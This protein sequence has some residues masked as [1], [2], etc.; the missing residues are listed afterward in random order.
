[1]TVVYGIDGSR[2][3]SL[4]DFWLAMGEA[5]NGPGGYFGRNLD[6]FSDCLGG[7]F[8][9]PEDDDY[10]AAWHHHEQSRA[11]LGYPE[12]VRQLERRL[13]RCHPSNRPAVRAD[14]EA[15]P[16]GQ[17][18]TVFDWLAEIFED[19]IPGRLRLE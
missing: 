16:T 7:G 8:G 12:T 6:A 13:A 18:P 3:R 4:E 14:L 5:V 11:T 15:A 2:I 10:I 9:T 19:Q 17:G 1:V